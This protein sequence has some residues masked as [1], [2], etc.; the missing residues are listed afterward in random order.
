MMYYKRKEPTVHIPNK[1]RELLF[2][3]IASADPGQFG[4]NDFDFKLNDKV[5]T[6]RSEDFSKELNKWIAW[7]KLKDD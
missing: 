4:F 1:W 2:R 6:A 7:E 3:E 5:Y